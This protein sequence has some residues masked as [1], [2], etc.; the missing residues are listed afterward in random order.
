MREVRTA[1]T[2]DLDAEPPC[3][4]R[5]DAA[6][7][8]PSTENWW[9]D[10][11]WEHALGG[12]ARARVGRRRAGRARVRRPAAAAARRA[13]AAHRLRRGRRACAPTAR[14]RGH[15]A[16]LMDAL[17]RGS[18]GARTTWARSAATDDGARVLRGARLA[19]VGGPDVGAHAGRQSCGPRR[20]TSSIYVLPVRRAARPVAA[21]CTCD[22]RDTRAADR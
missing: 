3:G 19:A 4:R 12:D 2:A 17:E 20:R 15:G 11:D 5:P 7:T 6:R 14:R 10:H 13:G 9:T 1:H 18:C 21:S 22:W 8:P 16:A